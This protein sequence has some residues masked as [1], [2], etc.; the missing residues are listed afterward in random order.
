VLGAPRT[1]FLLSV[2]LAVV[3]LLVTA[4]PITLG[5]PTEMVA[6]VETPIVAATVVVLASY[7]VVYEAH[8]RRV[9][10][11]ESAVPDFLDRL[12]SV[13]EAGTSVV[14][15]VRRVADSNLEALTDDLQ[16]TR[17]DIDWGADVGTALRRLE[18]RV[19]SP[20]TSRAVAL[21]TNAMRASGDVG[22]VLRIA[23]DESRARRGRSVGSADR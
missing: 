17:R 9:R 10:R 6:Q 8:K 13:N 11:I 20:M 18:R 1:V 7:A 5:P 21:I 4:F 15:S 3:V 2:P 23:A 22:P 12:A 16:R 19:R 14:G